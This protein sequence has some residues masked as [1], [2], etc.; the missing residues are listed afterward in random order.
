MGSLPWFSRKLQHSDIL[1]NHVLCFYVFTVDYVLVV[2]KSM[3]V[4]QN[5]INRVSSG[6]GSGSSAVGGTFTQSNLSGASLFTFAHNTDTYPASVIIWKSDGTA[7]RPSIEALST[8]QIRV[9]LSAIAPISGTAIIVVQPGVANLA[10]SSGSGGS[11]TGLGIQY[12]LLIM[13]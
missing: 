13:N 9:D 5:A 1:W 6:G 8:N 10:P 12:P 3:P 4:L 11:G 2:L 7:Y